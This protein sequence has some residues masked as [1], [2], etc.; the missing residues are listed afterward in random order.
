MNINNLTK[1][2]LS[3]FPEGIT[4][5][6]LA[7]LIYFSHKFL[8][9]ENTASY[10]DIKYIRMPLGPVPVG[11]RN[12]ALD[13]DIKITV[14]N[15]VNLRFDVQLYK[16]SRK[17]NFSDEKSAELVSYLM[18]KIGKIQTSDLVEDSHKDPSW[19]NHANGEE[20]FFTQ[21]D[22]ERKM[23]SYRAKNGIKNEDQRLQAKLVEGMI[24]EI[25]DESTSLEYPHL[26][27]NQ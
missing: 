7:K 10:K 24:T 27:K 11:F 15:H 3:N 25:V 14:L 8:V 9:K 18:T 4:K 20:Y 1:Q 12:L 13:K 23:P 2:I 26:S 5:V 16:L 21:E 17:Q 6:K 22:V 19:L